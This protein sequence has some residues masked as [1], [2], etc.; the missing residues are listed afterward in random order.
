MYDWKW[1]FVAFLTLRQA[2]TEASKG[3]VKV[4][5]T[6]MC[7][8]LSLWCS[9]E[10]WLLHIAAGA[11]PHFELALTGG[12]SK[13]L[14]W[15]WQQFF[16]RVDRY[17]CIWNRKNLIPSSVLGSALLCAYYVLERIIS[18]WICFMIVWNK[19]VPFEYPSIMWPVSIFMLFLW[20]WRKRAPTATTPPGFVVPNKGSLKP[21]VAVDFNFRNC[22]F[23]PNYKRDRCTYL[24]L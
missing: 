5:F 9:S 3:N 6:S 2:P 1:G 17:W 7:L 10:Q 24:A 16:K 13:S 15:T 20:L 19:N 11:V 22:H 18:F 4:M 23:T 12:D 8:N 21:A 14:M